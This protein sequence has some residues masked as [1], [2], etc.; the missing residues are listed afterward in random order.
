M[1]WWESRNEPQDRALAAAARPEHADELSF[2]GQ[3][4]HDKGHIFDGGELLWL[5]GVVGLG[6]FS[7]LHHMWPFDFFWPAHVIQ[8]NS[9]AY[10]LRGREGSWSGGSWLHFLS[11][12]LLVRVSMA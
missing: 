1:L 12:E 2:G 3:I 9:H 8:H 10:G 11:A 5:A 7:E 6:D 4:L